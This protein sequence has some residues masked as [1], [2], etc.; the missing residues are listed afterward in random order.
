M[1]ARPVLARSAILF[2]PRHSMQARPAKLCGKSGGRS[3]SKS[4]GT[5]GTRSSGT[6]GTRSS[7][8]S[9]GH[10]G[11]KT[12]GWLAACQASPTC[13]RLGCGRRRQVASSRVV[14]NHA[15]P[16]PGTRREVTARSRQISVTSKHA[17]RSQAFRNTPTRLV[18]NVIAYLKRTI[19]PRAP[20]PGRVAASSPV[21]QWQF[22]SPV[23][24]PGILASTRG[25]RSSARH[26]GAPKLRGC[27]DELAARKCASLARETTSTRCSSL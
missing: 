23:R 8:K 5:S 2:V 4:S 13:A 25:S 10:P 27:I 12:G 7:G 19:L 1:S 6:A 22:H 26:V 11:G 24:S 15:T 18:I 17:T 16:R 14:S 9:G 20:R 21:C 3:G